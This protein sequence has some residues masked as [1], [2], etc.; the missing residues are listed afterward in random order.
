MAKKEKEVKIVV[1][2]VKTSR[3]EVEIRGISSL[4]THQ[5]PED[6]RTSIRNKRTGQATNKKEPIDP[7]AQFES[8]KY[9]VPDGNGT[10]GF[11]AVW[12]KRAMVA[13]GGR[14]AQ[15]L[16]MT[17]LRGAFHVR[18]IPANVSGGEIIPMKHSKPVMREDVVK[19]PSGGA[20]LRWR[21]EFREWSAKFI[22]EYYDNLLTLDQI[23]NLVKLAG[24]HNGLGED[25][26][27]KKGGLWGRFEV[28]PSQIKK[29]RKK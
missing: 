21:P 16:P 28:V 10:C 6:A 11:P 8:G 29:A 23:I 14:Y 1:P 27:E 22:V 7:E 18:G 19:L 12:I 2:E 5:F 25:R 17:F 24:C 15:G 13:V 4:V 26:P 3:V 20:D 9:K